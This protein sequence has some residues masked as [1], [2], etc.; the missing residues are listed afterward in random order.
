M[1]LLEITIEP[2]V[3]SLRAF[4]EQQNATGSSSQSY[5]KNDSS[6]SVTGVAKSKIRSNFIPVEKTLNLE[7]TQRSA[8]AT[9]SH[10]PTGPTDPT[11]PTDV[12]GAAE[13]PVKSENGADSFAEQTEDKVDATPTEEGSGNSVDQANL[14][15]TGDASAASL[16]TGDQGNVGQPTQES[17]DPAQFNIGN[18]TSSNLDPLVSPTPST[19]KPI[20]TS[21]R[22][23]NKVT[24]RTTSETSSLVSSKGIKKVTES[25]VASTT[26]IR[27]PPSQQT[28]PLQHKSQERKS[29]IQSSPAASTST[30]RSSS[31]F[32]RSPTKPISKAPALQKE[33]KSATPKVAVHAP[34]P[35][36][37]ARVGLFPETSY[38]ALK[39]PRSVEIATI[40]KVKRGSPL[41][42][43]PSLRHSG[44]SATQPLAHRTPPKTTRPRSAL[45]DSSPS[46]SRRAVSNPPRPATSTSNR[47]SQT[48]VARSISLKNVPLG[49]DQPDLPRKEE[50]SIIPGQDYSH[51]PTFMR[52]TQ[53]SSSKAVPRSIGASREADG[54]KHK[55]GSFKV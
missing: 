14:H 25:K 3:S 9:S 50:A 10:D 28:S 22:T 11:D 51:L 20:A 1:Y 12:T 27:T 19:S 8:D 54:R 53:A 44:A 24:D 2:K 17:D 6:G 35:T 55:S 21:P 37:H 39:T 33:P 47:P 38:G 32:M 36:P 46:S 23:P 15:V 26:P 18:A 48:T 16:T 29:A 45:G 34:A 30:R 31:P 43:Q 7:P 13:Q 42:N 49:K 41:T 52:P 40:T 4:F 5:D